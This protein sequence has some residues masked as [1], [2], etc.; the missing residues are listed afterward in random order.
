MDI[1]I[2]SNLER[3]LYITLGSE[4]TAEY[5]KKLSSEGKYT[6]S[7][8][9]FAKI[10]ESFVGYYTDEKETMETVKATYENK[11]HLID[12]HTAVAVNAAER[13]MSENKATN[14]MLVVSTASPYKF[15]RD[16]YLSLTGKTVGDIEALSMLSQLTEVEIPTP[17]CEILNKKVIHT[18]LID[19]S[20]MDAAVIDFI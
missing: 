3:L 10:S 9:D 4:K 19:K 14:T 5:M 17:L 13:Y 11:N 7:P 1:L 12:T 18:G 8:E 20:E 6:L 16:V 2:S 15:A